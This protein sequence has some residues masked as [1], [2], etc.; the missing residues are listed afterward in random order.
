MTLCRYVIIIAT[1]PK[2][3]LTLMAGATP[4]QQKILP[5]S[6]FQSVKTIADQKKIIRE[7]ETKDEI[8]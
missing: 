2:S 3:R 1:S 6:A 8:L 5:H 4:T 7:V